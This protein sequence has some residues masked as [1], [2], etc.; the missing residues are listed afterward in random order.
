VAGQQCEATV[1]KDWIANPI[2]FNRRDSGR[3]APPHFPNGAPFAMPNLKVGSAQR[4]LVKIRLKAT[5]GEEGGA[6]D[7]RGGMNGR[8]KGGLNKRLHAATDARGRPV[9]FF[10]PAD[11]LSDQANG[12]AMSDV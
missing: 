5:A 4:R 2:A 3:P 9:R 6:D 7:Q 11:Q 12:S 1:G 8:R 10:M